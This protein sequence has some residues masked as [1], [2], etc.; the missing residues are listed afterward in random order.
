MFNKLC[1]G[2]IVVIFQFAFI[3]AQS[4]YPSVSDNGGGFAH[5][6][7][8]EGKILFSSIGQ[9]VMGL[10]SDSVSLEAGFITSGITITKIEER[11][12][13][14]PA[15]PIIGNFY[16]NPFNSSTKID[17]GLPSNS[18]LSIKLFDLSGNLIY[19]YKTESPAGNYTFTF[20]SDNNLPSG[21]YFYLIRVD[22]F[23]KTGKIV[24]IK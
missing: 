21:T 2:L 8:G 14:L 15:S 19:S 10:C 13:K 3:S 22:N 6:S 1:I 20:S 7:A 24:M 9:S 4:M 23:Q 17:I 11:R 12:T 5:V 16:P 18:A